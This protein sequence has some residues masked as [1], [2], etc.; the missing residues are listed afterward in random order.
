MPAGDDLEIRRLSL[1]NES[2]RTRELTLTR[3]IRTGPLEEAQ[4]ELGLRK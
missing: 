1:T 3:F 4:R 2:E